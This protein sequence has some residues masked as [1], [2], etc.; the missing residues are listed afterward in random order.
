MRKRP[1]TFVL[2]SLVFLGIAASFPVQIGVLYSHGL[3]DLGLILQKLTTFNLVCMA[4]LVML[5]TMAWNGTR[6]IYMG[7]PLAMTVV[8]WNNF[9][10]GYWGYDY[11]LTT[12]FYSSLMFAALCMFPFLPEYARVIQNPRIRWWMV[13]ARK[14][15]MIPVYV[16]QGRGHQIQ[17]KTKDISKTGAFIESQL[18]NPQLGEIVDL[19]L[20]ISTLQQLQLKAEVVRFHE[21][22]EGFGVRFQDMA[23]TEK[24]MLDKYLQ[25]H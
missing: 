2:T 11:S 19:N 20:K 5:A 14:E 1:W 23:A 7:I 21:D 3:Q 12:T 25:S 8:V 6:W 24:K 10:V 22:R 9:L 13:A 16:T 17:T 18:K 15:I 4:C